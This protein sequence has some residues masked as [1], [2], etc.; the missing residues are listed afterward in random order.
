MSVVLVEVG[1]CVYFY[2]IFS[3]FILYCVNGGFWRTALSGCFYIKYTFSFNLTQKESILNSTVHKL[4][5]DKCLVLYQLFIK[6]QLCLRSTEGF[7]SLMTNLLM[8]YFY[9]FYNFG[10]LSRW[11]FDSVILTF[12]FYL[13]MK[14]VCNFCCVCKLFQKCFSDIHC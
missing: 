2:Q 11:V 1:S 10:L 12:S 13:F 14:F 7:S 5:F 9:S 6:Q 8:Q 3:L 4:S